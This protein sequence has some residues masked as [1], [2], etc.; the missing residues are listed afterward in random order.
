MV[1]E[2]NARMGDPETEV[3]IPRVKSDLLDLFIAAADGTLGQKSVEVS[4]EYA[5]AVMLVSGGYPGDYEKGKVISG[6]DRVEGSIL[7]HAGTGMKDGAVVTSGG[8]VIA[9]TSLGKTMNEALS[10][11]YHN[12]IR[13][14]FEKIYYRR[15]LGRD[16]MKFI[17]N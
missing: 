12:A 2:Y 5:A 17:K 9:V 4:S 13:I 3:V 10:L 8:R 6:L 7:F 16:L 11:S 15:D 1:I 14:S